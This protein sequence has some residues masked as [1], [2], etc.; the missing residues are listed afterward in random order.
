MATIRVNHNK[1]MLSDEKSTHCMV[2]FC[3]L[4]EQ[5]IL[6]CS[7]EARSL[8]AKTG[9]AG[10]RRIGC[11]GSQRTFWSNGNVLDQGGVHR[12]DAFD[13]GFSLSLVA[14]WPLY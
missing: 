2:P 10:V 9:S 7:E 13:K 4:L 1:I 3:E 6:I 5:P 11:K 14:L 12:V 8:I